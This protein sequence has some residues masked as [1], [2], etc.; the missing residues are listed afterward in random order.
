MCYFC[1]ILKSI[2]Q[3]WWDWSDSQEDSFSLL[4]FQ[5]L[6]SFAGL[7]GEGGGQGGKPSAGCK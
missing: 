5:A 7:S 6:N 3:S 1:N 4:P 2:F